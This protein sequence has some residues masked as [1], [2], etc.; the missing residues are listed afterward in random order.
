MS[1]PI[2]VALDY[3]VTPVL[4][5]LKRCLEH[6]LRMIK[7]PVCRIPITFHES[8]PAADGCDCFCEDGG[9]GQGWVRWVDTAP[10]K[11]AANTA[12]SACADGIFDVIVEAGLY[13]CWPVPEL[14]PLPEAEEQDAALGLMLDSM[15]LRKSLQCCPAFAGEPWEL[16]RA[17][18]TG[19]LGGCIGSVIQARFIR[20]DCGCPDPGAHHA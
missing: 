16:V 6:Q 20:Y 19:P 13:R 9:Q 14:G 3:G 12:G 5:N 11:A 1:Q 7:R 15:A 8:M 18:P 17:E 10:S 2:Q 4:W